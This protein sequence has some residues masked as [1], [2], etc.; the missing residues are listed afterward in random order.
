M[1]SSFIMMKE[2]LLHL[3]AYQVAAIR[4]VSGGS[5][6][7][8]GHSGHSPGPKNK[9]LIIFMSGVLGSLLPHF[10]FCVA[11][12]GIDMPLPEPSIHSRP[13]LSSSWGPCFQEP[14]FC[15]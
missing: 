10:L 5:L 8:P 6:C 11:E 1:G 7:C 14:H 2:G 13:F 4:I 12:E 9:I 15:Q 3:T